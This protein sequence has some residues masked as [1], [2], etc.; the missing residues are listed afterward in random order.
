M[1]IPAPVVLLFLAGSDGHSG[2][3]GLADVL[4]GL[5]VIPAPVVLL[6]LAGSDG[7]AESMLLLVG[8]DGSDGHAESGDHSGHATVGRSLFAGDHSGHATAGRC[9]LAGDHSGH[10]AAGRCLF[11]TGSGIEIMQ[12]TH[13]FNAAV[14]GKP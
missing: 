8:L 12:L 14:T 9:L 1:V 10:A 5:M 11:A 7:H 13:S 6:C 2:S 3:S 4:M